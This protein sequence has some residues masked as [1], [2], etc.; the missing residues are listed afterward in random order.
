MSCFSTGSRQL[1][2]LLEELRS[3][4]NVV[5][6][7]PDVASYMPFVASLLHSARERDQ[8]VV[9]LRGDATLQRLLAAYGEHTVVDLPAHWASG[10]SLAALQDVLQAAGGGYCLVSDPLDELLR[11]VAAVPSLVEFFVGICPLLYDLRTVAYWSLVR[12]RCDAMSIAGVKDC[13]QVFMVLDR[14]GSDLVMTPIK[15]FGRYSEAMFRPHRVTMGTELVLQPT[16]PDAQAQEDYVGA[17][18]GKNRELAAIRDALDRSN[19]ELRGRNAELAE[20]NGRLLKQNRAYQALS[21]SLRHLQAVLS[22]GQA[23]GGSLATDQVYLAIAAAAHSLFRA[24]V[25][26][27]RLEGTN[28]REAIDH[29][30]GKFPGLQEVL[31]DP[32]IALLRSQV[33]ETL[34]ARCVV[35]PGEAATGAGSAAIAPLTARECCVG[36]LELYAP[37]ARLAADETPILL[38]YLASEAAIALDNARLYGELQVQGELLRTYVDKVIAS[39]EAESRNL[40]LDLHDGLVQEIVAAY[41]HLQTAQAW[42][43][44]EPGAEQRELE[45]GVQLLRRAIQEARRLIAR[46][47]PAGLDDLGLVHALRL[48]VAQASSDADRQVAL[49][50]DA[51]WPRLT[52]TL[53]AALFRIVQEALGNA[54]RYAAADRVWVSLRV[55]DQELCVGVEDSG[56]GFDVAG[57]L[58]TPEEGRHLGLIGIRERARMWGG[59]CVIDSHP[60]AGTRI[61][62]HMPRSLALVG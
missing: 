13:T 48:H 50:V 60:G 15:V 21:D 3:G 46:L 27:L 42:R 40:A 25:C 26:R 43:E 20:L 22:A 52:P 38:G 49:N 39:D 33:R 47:R 9:Y 28:G 30:Q 35:L 54:L 37:D 23:I 8:R 56:R 11:G 59:R 34:R 1:D 58:S 36:S 24:P 29:V 12:G 10:G 18:A 55:T 4:D 44:R 14:S 62:V 6:Y 16:L 41:Q 45:C 7:T 53:E 5:W 32:A 2:E 19:Q 61:E 57:A 51:S 17:L 31:A